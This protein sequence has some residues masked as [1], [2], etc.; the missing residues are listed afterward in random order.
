M[1]LRTQLLTTALAV[2]LAA[3]TTSSTGLAQ[4]QGG[5]GGAMQ[6]GVTVHGHWTIDVRNKDGSLASHT[7]FENALDPDGGAPLLT[8]FLNGEF[9]PAY[10]WVHLS[11]TPAAPCAVPNGTTI[12]SAGEPAAILDDPVRLNTSAFLNLVRTVP[13]D[14]GGRP[15]GTITLS[16]FVKVTNPS[17]GIAVNY[18]STTVSTCPGDT[19]PRNCTA[20]TDTLAMTS[21]LLATPIPVAPDQI[22]QVKVTLSFS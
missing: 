2:T 12:C 13:R 10:W 14:F 20:P 4:A 5:K 18:V 3:A 11:G 19:P 16:G 17:P 9:V 1:T 15:V 7:E 22:V 21:H 8:G 6:A